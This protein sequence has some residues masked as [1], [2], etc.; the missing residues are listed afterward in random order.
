MGRLNIG[1]WRLAMASAVL[2]Y[3]P[4]AFADEGLDPQTDKAVAAAIRLGHVQDAVRIL[5]RTAQ[6]GTAEAKYQL[7]ALYRAGQGIE[8]DEKKAHRWMKAAAEQGH[9]KAQY[10]L[11]KMYFDGRGATADRILAVDWLRKAALQGHGQAIKFLADMPTAAPSAARGPGGWGAT[12]ARSD[13][14]PARSVPAGGASVT[15]SSELSPAQPE[16]LEAAWR[17]QVKAVEALIGSGT[18][19]NAP[20]IDANTALGLASA[21]LPN[22]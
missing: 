20:G 12:I 8:R 2:I 16:I 17:G 22:I 11:G 14:A 6:G 10:S 4:F 3:A 9:A 15:K 7:G 21:S 5:E 18:A 1:R 19:V 13:T